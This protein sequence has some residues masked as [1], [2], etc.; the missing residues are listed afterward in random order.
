MKQFECA[1]AR[2]DSLCVGLQEDGDPAEGL[3][4]LDV[5]CGGRLNAMLLTPCSARALA[6]YLLEITDGNT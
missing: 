2:N 1:L 5:E 4:L 6:R 3:V